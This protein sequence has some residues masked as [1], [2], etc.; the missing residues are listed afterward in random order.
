MG[1]PL[2]RLPAGAQAHVRHHESLLRVRID[3]H[4]GPPWTLFRVRPALAAHRVVWSDIARTLGAVALVG[5][6][7]PDLIP[8]NSCYLMAAPDRD[9]ALALSGWLNSTWIRVF[10]RAIADPASNGFARFTA[11]VIAETPLPDRATRDTR[12]VTLAE[13]GMR[14]ESVQEQLDAI[15][16]EHLGLSAAVR[17]QLA[18]APGAGANHRG[19]VTG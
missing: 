13:A 6:A 17:A 14:G 5:P 2:P 3:Y 11:R 8:L 10:A 7:A 15:C 16:A 4:D 12:L 1:Q 19:R 9:T 18:A